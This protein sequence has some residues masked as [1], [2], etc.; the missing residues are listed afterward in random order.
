[1]FVGN[2][3][4]DTEKEG[5]R[6]ESYRITITF[7]QVKNFVR[8]VDEEKGLIWE[9]L[10]YEMKGE[11]PYYERILESVQERGK[12][13][14]VSDLPDLLWTLESKE[15]DNLEKAVTIRWNSKERER[16]ILTLSLVSDY[17]IEFSSIEY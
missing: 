16:F 9:G 15:S 13:F 8:E 10:E 2:Y 1:M 3:S 4:W 11:G 12:V 17:G 6:A 7:S 5:G 14:L